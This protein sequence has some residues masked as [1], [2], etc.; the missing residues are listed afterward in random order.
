[1]NPAVSDTECYNSKHEDTVRVNGVQTNV[2]RSYI[3]INPVIKRLIHK[4][5]NFIDTY[6]PNPLPEFRPKVPF[7]DGRIVVELKK[8]V[9]LPF[10]VFRYNGASSLIID[11]KDRSINEFAIHF[12]KNS[13]EKVEAYTSTDTPN[14]KVKIFIDS[15]GDFGLAHFVWLYT[16]G[17]DEAVVKTSNEEAR[18]WFRDFINAIDSTSDIANTVTPHELLDRSLRTKTLEVMISKPHKNLNTLGIALL[19]GD[20]LAR[21]ASELIVTMSDDT[22]SVSQI[23]YY[24]RGDKPIHLTLDLDAKHRIEDVIDILSTVLESDNVFN[25]IKKSLT[26]FLEAYVKMKVVYT[27]ITI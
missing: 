27:Y 9:I 5:I 14:S 24:F 4:L 18:K 23:K 16:Q 12:K 7:N 2:C 3:D 6:Y 19:L 10:I 20:D 17:I 11:I 13:I 25:S 22:G 8:P 26:S 21:D 1:M 15:D